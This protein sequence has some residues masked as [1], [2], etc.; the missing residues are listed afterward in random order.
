[1]QPDC[2]Q[3]QRWTSSTG[4]ALVVDLTAQGPW[5]P[6]RDPYYSA[7]QPAIAAAGIVSGIAS[8]TGAADVVD[9]AADSLD[10]N[11]DSAQR[12]LEG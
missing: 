1:M 12:Q 11:H 3:R 9:P 4:D 2:P 7:I 8:T 6:M 5:L 10:W